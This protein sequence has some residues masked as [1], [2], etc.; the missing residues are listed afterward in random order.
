MLTEKNIT[1]Y[2]KRLLLLLLLLLLVILAW[3]FFAV[4]EYYPHIQITVSCVVWRRSSSA[5]C[6]FEDFCHHSNFWDQCFVADGP[7]LQNSLPAG[8][9]QMDI[10]YEQFKQLQKTLF[11]LGVEITEHC[12]YLFKLHLSSEWASIG[13]VETCN[14]LIALNK[15]THRPDDPRGPALTTWCP[16]SQY[17][18]LNPAGSQTSVFT[19]VSGPPSLSILQQN[20]TLI[21]TIYSTHILMLLH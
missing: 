21:Q 15:T 12:D 17:S 1:G 13:T 10:S 5:F 6:Q 11:C 18:K 19:I 4:Q 3:Q 14:I 7:R 16:L 8:L 2:Q 9:R 20:M